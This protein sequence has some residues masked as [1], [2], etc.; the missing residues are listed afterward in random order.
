MG[1]FK[2]L[3]WHKMSTNGINERTLLDL[4]EQFYI[5][6]GFPKSKRLEFKILVRT[7]ILNFGSRR[8][9]YMMMKEMPRDSR[10]A[11]E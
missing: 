1:S 7:E 2:C 6:S 9:Q 11:V 4:N 3:Y 5:R 10:L 8:F